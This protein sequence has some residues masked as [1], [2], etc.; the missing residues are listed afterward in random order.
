MLS[1]YEAAIMVAIGLIA[2]NAWAHERRAQRWRAIVNERLSGALPD[3]VEDSD[4]ELAEPYW[5][6]V[7]RPKIQAVERG[8][9]RRLAPTH[10]QRDMENKLRLAGIRQSPEIYFFTRMVSSLA[11]L[12]MAAI[13]TMMARTLPLNERILG[14]V[15]LAGMVYVYPGIHLNTKFQQRLQEIDRSLPEVFDLLSVSVEAG[16]AFDAALRRVVAN[17]SGPIKDELGRVLADMQ[18]GIPRAEALQ[19]L[20][21]RT[22][23]APLKR[24]AGLVAQSDRTGSSISTALKVQAKDIKEYRA[25]KARE[26]AASIP[27]K[28]IFPMVLFI[29]PAMFIVILGPA[30]ISV[31]Q[32]M[33]V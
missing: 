33:H 26:K 2:L 24:F 32:L 14:P 17:V 25:A 30:V 5:D 19:G 11:V 23:S 8:F 6:R 13:G 7:I 12:I 31:L 27:I 3:P 21:R 29:F 16:L 10:V 22:Q 20:A 9:V 4:D 18:L 28:I 1:L 15:L